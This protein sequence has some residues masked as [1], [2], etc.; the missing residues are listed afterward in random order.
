MSA[1]SGASNIGYGNVSPFNNSSL[2]NGTNSN[3]SGSFSS[4]EIPGCPGLVGVKNNVDAAAG[5]YSF[6]GGAKILKRKIKN[7]TKR[8]KMK[9]GRKSRKSLRRRVKTRALAL[10]GGRKNSKN[11]RD[12]GTRRR[13]KKY[14][15]GGSQFFNNFPNTPSYSVGGILPA[16]ELGLANP[17]PIKVWDG[18]VNNID[19][20]NHFTGKGFPSAGH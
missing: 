5:K 9:G 4:N 19:N 14:M 12:R 15:K 13:N 8:Y 10:A 6:K 20:Y 16:N 11:R 18:N 7:I 2:V 17:P 3:Y 1:G